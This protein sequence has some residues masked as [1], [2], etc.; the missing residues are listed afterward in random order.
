[1]AP[2]RILLAALPGILEEIVAHVLGSEPDVEVAG[3]IRSLNGL[4]QK[5]A[6]ERPDVVILGQN[7]VGLATALLEEH[8]RMT[9]L[10][11]AEEARIAWVYALKLEQ[12]RLGVLSPTTLVS[13]IRQAA[14]ST[15]SR[16]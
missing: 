6:L 14:G 16:A 13:A 8:P 5:V 4:P 2:T 1:L 12:I 11:V 10:A 3:T 7:D 9:V 15:A